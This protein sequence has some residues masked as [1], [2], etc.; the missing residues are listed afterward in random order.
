[1][2]VKGLGRKKKEKEFAP[3]FMSAA[4]PGMIEEHSEGSGGS[5]DPELIDHVNDLSQGKTTN[6]HPSSPRKRSSM[7]GKFKKKPK[8]SQ[9]VDLD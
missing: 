1:M 4:G 2:P 5:E 9:G 6:N 8:E 3:R 7:L